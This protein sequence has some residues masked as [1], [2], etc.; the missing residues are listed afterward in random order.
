MAQ[1]NLQLSIFFYFF[2]P[3]MLQ[4]AKRLEEYISS[5]LLPY[6]KEA[7]LFSR[8]LARLCTVL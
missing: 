4:K 8:V 1:A 5:N 3:R 6:Q 7:S 2:L